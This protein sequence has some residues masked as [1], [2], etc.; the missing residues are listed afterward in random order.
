MQ[1]DL[2][3]GEL[4]PRPPFLGELLLL[5][6][7]L[8]VGIAVLLSP[9]PTG[10]EALSSLLTLSEGSSRLTLDMLMTW[11]GVFLLVA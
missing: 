9:R 10:G 1:R 7:F 5:S 6:V 8:G 4:A 3:V 11:V 2:N